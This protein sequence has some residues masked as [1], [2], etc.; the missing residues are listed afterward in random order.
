M[1]I[2]KQTFI[3]L[4]LASGMTAAALAYQHTPTNCRAM[5]QRDLAA[6]VQFI[7]NVSQYAAPQDF[8]ATLSKG[9]K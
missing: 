8:L 1:G 9:S 2:I 3:T 6:N 5:V 4:G 7:G